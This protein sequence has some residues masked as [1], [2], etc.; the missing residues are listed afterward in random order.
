MRRPCPL[1]LLSSFLLL[2]PPLL[3]KAAV[4]INETETCVSTDE[5][6]M[7]HLE[8]S[9]YGAKSNHHT[10]ESYWQR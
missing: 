2:S 7:N 8:K 10:V 6:A 1:V 5:E 9:Q 3:I 4:F